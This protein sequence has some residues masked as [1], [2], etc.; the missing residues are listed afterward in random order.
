MHQFKFIFLGALGTF[1]SAWLGL[2]LLPVVHYG[3]EAKALE[4]GAPLPERELIRRGEQVYAANGCVYC[5]TQQVRSP[6]YGN[7]HL[8]FWGERRSVA[9]DYENDT[10]AFLGTMR[11]GPD[12]SNVGQRL[13]SAA[14][15]YQHLYEPLSTSPGSV[16]PAHRFLFER[17]PVEN[18]VVDPEA[19]ALDAEGNRV[20]AE[21]YQ[22]VPSAEARALVAYLLSLQRTVTPR[23]EAEEAPSLR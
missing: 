16:M 1:F 5:H 10:I 11:T 20:D 3:A 23:P 9:A 6:S 4:P 15:H 2:V 14:W 18:G 17:K 22:R 19:V 12:L 8:R 7:D 21:G 13:S